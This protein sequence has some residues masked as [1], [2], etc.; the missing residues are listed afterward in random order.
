VLFYSTVP[1]SGNS[2]LYHLTLPTDPVAAPLQ[3]GTGSTWNFQLRPTFW[4]G[5]IMC[6]DQAAPNPGAHCA[7][8]S[9]TNIHQSL[10]PH[11][12]NYFGLT[13]GQ[14]FMEM[15]FYP[16]GWGPISCTDAFGTQDGKW[17]PAINMES[18]QSNWNP[19]VPTNAAGNGLLGPEPVN[20][21]V[22]TKS[23]SPVA[24]ASPAPGFGNQAIVTADTLEFNNGDQLTVD[25]H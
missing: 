22:L 7:A 14:G 21:A 18:V 13:P 3:N 24:P 16:P 6:D 17:S 19:G 25:M 4:L 2:N 5:M 15:Q 23:G 12:P 20:F 8:D 11:S 1:G 9:D 10:D